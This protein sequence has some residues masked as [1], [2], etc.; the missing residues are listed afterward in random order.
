VYAGDLTPRMPVQMIPGALNAGAVGTALLGR[1][2]DGSQKAVFAVVCADGSIVQ[3]HTLK[4]LDGLAPPGTVSP[5]P[6]RH[7]LNDEDEDANVPSRLGVLLNYSPT[8]ILYVSEPLDDSILALDL[9]DDGIVFHVASMHRIRSEWLKEPIDLAPATI[10]TSDPNWASNTTLDVQADFYVANRGNNTILR[11]RQDGTVVAARRLRLAE[12]RSLGN[13][14]LNGIAGS[15]DGS[16]IWLTVTGHLPGAE[17]LAG[18][19]LE[20]PAF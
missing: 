14:R 7:H 5:L 3:E 12:G 19:V 20:A 2:P 18:A 13:L 11:M 9:A 8:R 16:K 15:S 1:S 17:H 10:E 6:G 4:G